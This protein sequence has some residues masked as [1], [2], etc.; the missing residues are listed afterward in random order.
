MR[1]ILVAFTVLA[2]LS[3][4]AVTT[5]L[6]VPQVVEK[7]IEWTCSLAQPTET[8]QVRMRVMGHLWSRKGDLARAELWY[9]Q[10][11]G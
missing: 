8:C 9:P 3:V 2:V 1:R 10:P 7:T 6:T 5:V 4:V 11:V